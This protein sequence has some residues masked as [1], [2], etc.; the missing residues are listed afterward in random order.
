MVVYYHET[1]C[2][3]EKL[4]CYLQGQ[5]HS[6]GLYNQNMSVSMSSKVLICLQANFVQ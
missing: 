4:V 1:E 5:G 3:A 2:H 6:E